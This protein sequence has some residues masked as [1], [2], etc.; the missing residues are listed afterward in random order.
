LQPQYANTLAIQ[1]SFRSTTIGTSY[2]HTNDISST[3]T[4]V[5]EGNVINM[6]PR[7]I[8]YQNNL[9]LTV[10][11][12][13]NLAKWWKLSLTGI[14][15]RLENK[16]GTLTYGNYGR[17]RFVGTINIQQAFNLP[18]HLTAEIAGV[19]NSKRI[20]GL[21]T[22][23][24]GNSQM[25]L[26]LQKNLF[27][28]KATLRL[29]ATDILR[30]NKISSNTQLNNLLLHTT[31]VGESRQIRLNFSYRFGNTSIKSKDN[32]KSGLETESQRL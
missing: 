24:N 1:Y 22:Y 27:Q 11:Q 30:T 16:V 14:G 19:V 9:N 2:T 31:Y 10:T 8:G 15:Y 12:Q 32:R 23:T 7:N 4:E 3:I 5:M 28:D 26:G 17:S 18:G 6:V 29:A 25:D 13:A 20:S 21:N